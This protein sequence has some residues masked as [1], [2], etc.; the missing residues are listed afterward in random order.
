M[1]SVVM[2][3]WTKYSFLFHTFGFWR[4]A[5]LLAQHFL[6]LLVCLSSALWGK[7]KK[8]CCQSQSAHINVGLHNVLRSRLK[9]SGLRI[10]WCCFTNNMPLWNSFLQFLQLS[11]TLVGY[12]KKIMSGFYQPVLH[13]NAMTNKHQKKSLFKVAVTY[14]YWS[15]VLCCPSR[16]W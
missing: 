10:S 8:H 3:P 11:N 15:R 5:A 12:P 16:D 2:T 6:E 7:E 4:A 14:Q 9:W 13:T 1:G